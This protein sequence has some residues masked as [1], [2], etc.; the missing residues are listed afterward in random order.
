MTEFTKDDIE[1]YRKQYALWTSRGRITPEELHL[2]G[3]LRDALDHIE[4][5]QKRVEEL[6]ERNQKLISENSTIAGKLAHYYIRVQELEQDTTFF[7]ELSHAWSKRYY[8]VTK[9]LRQRIA[10]LEQERRWINQDKTMIAK[11]DGDSWCFVLPDFVN[12][13]ESEAQF[14][15]AI[16]GRFL[17]KIYIDLLPQPPKDGE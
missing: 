13:Q 5:L 2:I 16:F 15:D 10:K 1:H 11:K 17:D 8:K 9:E 12:L 14:M 3:R 4:Q 6:N 7:R